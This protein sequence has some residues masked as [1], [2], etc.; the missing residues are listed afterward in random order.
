MDCFAM[1]LHCVWTT[2]SYE[3][4]VLKAANKRGDADTVA[5]VAGQIAGAIY[6]A[7]A[8]PSK[9]SLLVERWAQGD[10]SLRAWLLFHKQHSEV[11]AAGNLGLLSWDPP[12]VNWGTFPYTCNAFQTVLV[13][14]FSLL[15]SSLQRVAAQR[16]VDARS[17]KTDC[18]HMFG[19]LV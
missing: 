3:A 13:A 2:S 11:N 8:I 12:E 6:G 9:W 5:A 15:G 4:A 14:R 18:A 17:S 19:T 1:A 7:S 10:I 16:R